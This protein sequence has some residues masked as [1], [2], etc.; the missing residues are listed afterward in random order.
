V[1]RLQRYSQTLCQD[2]NNISLCA[3]FPHPARTRPTGSRGSVPPGDAPAFPTFAG[4]NGA[5]RQRLPG[6]AGASDA[7]ARDGQNRRAG[8]VSGLTIFFEGDAVRVI[9]GPFTSFCGVVEDVDEPRRASAEGARPLH[10]SRC[11]N[12]YVRDNRTSTSTCDRRNGSIM[13]PQEL[14]DGS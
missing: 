12:L 11:G 9:A 13:C 6:G 5:R 14:H 4:A 1:S 8:A 3:D 10:C 7:G 2:C